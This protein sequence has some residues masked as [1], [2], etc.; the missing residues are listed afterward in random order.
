MHWSGWC[1]QNSNSDGCLM[2]Q[3][4]QYV[5]KTILKT[6]QDDNMLQDYQSLLLQADRICRALELGYLRNPIF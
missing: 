6:D 4:N 5:P 3:T 2:G 1:P